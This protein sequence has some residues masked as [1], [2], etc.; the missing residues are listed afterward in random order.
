MSN[1]ERKKL[2][3]IILQSIYLRD[4][5]EHFLETDTQNMDSF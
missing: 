3:Q 1:L 5:T 4:K 2:S